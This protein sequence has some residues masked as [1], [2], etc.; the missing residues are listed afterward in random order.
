MEHLKG[1]P[2]RGSSD[3]GSEHPTSFFTVKQHYKSSTYAIVGLFCILA[4]WIVALALGDSPT[5]TSLRAK[6]AVLSPV[7]IRGAA[8][9]DKIY[10]TAKPLSLQRVAVQ[11]PFWLVLGHD[12]LSNQ[13]RGGGDY[14]SDVMNTV[15]AMNG[16]L[17]D[18]PSRCT[19]VDIG[20]NIGAV[21]MLAAATGC[22]VH[23][24][25]VQEF[26]VALT[27][28][29]AAVN[30]FDTLVNLNAVSDSEGE[31][32]SIFVRNTDNLGMTTTVKGLDSLTGAASGK[33]K[34]VTLDGY[35]E[36]NGIDRI[37]VLKI[38]VEGGEHAVVQGAKRLI[39]Q[40][41]VDIVLCELWH[42]HAVDILTWF[43][44]NGYRVHKV[45]K[46]PTPTTWLGPEL[47]P[48]E[49]QALEDALKP[50]SPIPLDDVVFVRKGLKI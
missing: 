40:Q 15:R 11:P 2:R 36:Q 25:D 19:F 34:T 8:F 22:K 16:W 12:L 17:R 31:D 6:G 42:H 43:H 33:V 29:S 45:A 32:M 44:Q 5:A 46:S 50:P 35:A 47:E 21:S 3:R 41:R 23:S 39:Q 14:P 10:K 4:L 38:D 48:S 1:A 18:L 30:G 13:V 26:A 20:C 28:A 27:T 9:L 37:A 7:R 49:F 24:F